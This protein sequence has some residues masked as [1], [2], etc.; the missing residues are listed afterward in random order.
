LPGP[1]RRSPGCQRADGRRRADLHRAVWRVAIG[2]PTLFFVVALPDVSAGEAPECAVLG[3][4]AAFA[5][6]IVAVMRP[7]ARIAH[8]RGR[9]RGSYSC[10][11]YRKPSDPPGART[12]IGVAPIAPATVPLLVSWRPHRKYGRSQPNCSMWVELA[13][14][15]LRAR[16]V[17]SRCWS[18]HVVRRKGRTYGG[19]D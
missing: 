6:L 1:Y 9:R 7:P 3:Q 8:E 17:G 5:V 12:V 19:T 10:P 13:C 4:L 2:F 14:S 18:V 15:A 16:R 11:R